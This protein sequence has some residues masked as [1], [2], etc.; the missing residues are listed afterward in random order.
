MVII[1]TWHNGLFQEQER[2]LALGL[3]PGDDLEAYH[4][5]FA[6]K[7]E[8]GSEAGEEED[9][10]HDKEK[11]SWSYSTYL[12]ALQREEVLNNTDESTFSS[13]MSDTGINTSVNCN[14]RTVACVLVSCV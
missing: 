4:D 9:S 3:S 7:G 6:T 5:P 13:L 2:R 14:I 1:I 11:V 10:H 8:E 12:A